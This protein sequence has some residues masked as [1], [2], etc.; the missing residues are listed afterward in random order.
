MEKTCSRSESVASSGQYLLYLK[1]TLCKANW[2][3]YTFGYIFPEIF[4]H[5]DTLLGDIPTV[6]FFFF[7]YV[8]KTPWYKDNEKCPTKKTGPFDRLSFWMALVNGSRGAWATLSINTLKCMSRLSSSF[9]G[10]GVRR[11]KDTFQHWLIIDNH[12]FAQPFFPPLV[13]WSGCT[14]PPPSYFPRGYLNDLSTK[15]LN[16]RCKVGPGNVWSRGLSFWKNG[17][18]KRYWK[19]VETGKPRRNRRTVLTLFRKSLI[20]R[21]LTRLHNISLW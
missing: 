9:R 11:Q 7:A 18:L 13:L 19:D 21:C 6:V 2:H 14:E 16:D 10:F 3:C 4:P 17:I 20:K 12:H 5:V 15:F 8:R 1:F